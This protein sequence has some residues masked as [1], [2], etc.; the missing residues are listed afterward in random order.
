MLNW[1]F[2]DHLHTM[3][4]LILYV[5]AMFQYLLLAPG[6]S[7]EIFQLQIDIMVAGMTVL[8]A[9]LWKLI[10]IIIRTL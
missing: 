8:L 4:T 2:L 7:D 10:L 6:F 1:L 9:T 5:C 3:M